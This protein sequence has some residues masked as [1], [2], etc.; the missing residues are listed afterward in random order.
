LLNPPPFS[1]KLA[2]A[3]CPPKRMASRENVPVPKRLIASCPWCLFN[4]HCES[5]HRWWCGECFDP[6]K[7]SKLRDLQRLKDAGLNY[8]PSRDELSYIDIT[9]QK[10][11][12]KV[13][14]NLCVE[15]C[16]VGEMM[17][18]AGSSGM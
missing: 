9:P 12:I 6:K 15:Y 11:C 17:A 16:L 13:F 2:D 8:L 10:A 18:G 7:I 4:R 14:N 3:C 1:G 5:C